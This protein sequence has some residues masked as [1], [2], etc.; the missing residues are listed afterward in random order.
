MLNR[1]FLS[2]ARRKEYLPLAVILGFAAILRFVG[3]DYG[4]PLWLVGDEVSHIFGALKM[5][6]LKT[7]LPALHLN[8]FAGVF[9][10]TPYLSYLYLLPFLFAAGIKFILFSGSISEFK[11]FLIVDPSIFFV[12]ARAVSAV[13]GVATVWIVYQAGYQLFLQKRV[14]LLSALFLAFSFLHVNYSHWARHWVAVTGFFALGIYVLANRSLSVGYRYMLVAAIIGVG[15]GFNVQVLLFGVYTL[16]WW[17]L[18]DREPILRL[19][20]R[21]WF[22]KAV[23]I[24]SALF[25]TGFLL[26]PRGYGFL[27]LAKNIN[28][29]IGGGRSLAGF[30]EIYWFYLSDFIKTEPVFLIFIVVGMAALCWS[31][32]R[33]AVVLG[34][35]SF[36]YIAAFYFMFEHVDRFILALYPIAA[37]L[38]GYGLSQVLDFVRSR[39]VAWATIIVVAVLLFIPVARYD[40][41]LVK[42]DT[43]TQAI[44]W[45]KNNLSAGAKV[46]VLA[47]LTRLPSAPTALA[48]QVGIDSESLRSVDRAE[49]SGADAADYKNSF[50]ALNLANISR[51][52]FFSGLEE[53]V[54]RERY[55]YIIFDSAFARLKGAAFLSD[56]FGTLLREYPGSEEPLAFGHQRIPDGFGDGLKELFFSSA[57][58]PS[59][60]IIKLNS[61]SE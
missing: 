50:H 31:Y 43:R 13:F 51:P 46:M 35:F 22:W 8:D 41:L 27:L 26:W 30:L 12:A 33:L 18:F 29:A 55:Q 36:L 1:V 6:E 60:K 25:G 45:A 34:G 10:Y 54:A 3:L 11:N 9:Y 48:E 49:M 7:L 59:I 23:A 57:L 4:L 39:R 19:L 56:N 53:Y 42:N 52:D 47:P 15:M 61:L 16:I 14:A 20:I 40:Y 21:S 28:P 24:F 17:F 44:N 5:L 37:V 32:R 2:L 58:G 38:A